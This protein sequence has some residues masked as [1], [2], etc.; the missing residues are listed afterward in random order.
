MYT[1]LGMSFSISCV[2]QQNVM[3]T[4]STLHINNFTKIFET[5]LSYSEYATKQIST[6]YLLEFD[7]GKSHHWKLGMFFKKVKRNLE[8]AWLKE[9]ILD[10]DEDLLNTP[11]YGCAVSLFEKRQ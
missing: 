7:R 10:Q 1:W 2:F 9:L 11:L 8:S 3:E 5:S 4:Y 6:N